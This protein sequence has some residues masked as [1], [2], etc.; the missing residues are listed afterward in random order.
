MT[1]QSSIVTELQ[2]QLTAALLREKILLAENERR[3]IE[4][5]TKNSKDFWKKEAKRNRDAKITDIADKIKAREAEVWKQNW[6]L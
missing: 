4:M 3:R 5:R 1:S 6:Y 2:R